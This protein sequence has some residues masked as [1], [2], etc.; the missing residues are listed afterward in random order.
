MSD[1]MF[2]LDSHLSS[3][4]SRVVSDVQAVATE[5]NMNIFLT[6][7]AMRDMLGGFPIGEIDFTLEGNTI[8]LAQ[9]IVKKTGATIVST[10]ENRKQVQLTFPSGVRAVLAMAREEKYSKP[11]AKPTVKAASIHEDLRGRDFT[12]NS[13]ALSLNPA[14]RGLL[15]D[16]TNCSDLR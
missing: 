9:T 1:Y 10:D 2:M 8:K 4:Q 13:I 15:L 5:A 16:P 11:G 12:I 14:S 3:D 7:G 6:G